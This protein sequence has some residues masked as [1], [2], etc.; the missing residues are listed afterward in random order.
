MFTKSKLS[1]VSLFSRPNTGRMF[2]FTSKKYLQ[3]EIRKLG[4]DVTP[5]YTIDKLI[6]VLQNN[7]SQ[8]RGN[9]L[10]VQREGITQ[11]GG[12]SNG[13]RGRGGT[14]TG[15]AVID[16]EEDPK[17]CAI[18]SLLQRSFQKRL[19]GKVKEHTS[20]GHVLEEPIFRNFM[21]GVN[22]DEQL[23]GLEVLGAYSSGLVAKKNQPWASDSVDFIAT[24]S[25][26]GVSIEACAV[27][28]KSRQKTSKGE[29]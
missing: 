16:E 22:Q 11:G 9:A 17:S 2:M 3:E 25:K 20:L 18:R 5:S 12:R 8:T 13:R 24:V 28:I 26:G 29:K 27:E 4:I 14:R 19:V 21:D 15:I 10:S 1:F 23:A 6:D 7:H